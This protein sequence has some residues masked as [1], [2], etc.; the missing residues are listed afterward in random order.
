MENMN[1]VWFVRGCITSGKSV[2]NR[3]SLNTEEAVDS[4]KK[5]MSEEK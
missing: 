4:V 1:D 2:R 3:N 5:S